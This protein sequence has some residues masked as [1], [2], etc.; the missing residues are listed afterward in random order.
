MT[1][2]DKLKSIFDAKKCEPTVRHIRFPHFK[3]L[4]PFLKLSFTTPITAIVGSNGSNK[5]SVLRA[6]ACCPHQENIGDHW[7]STDVDPID[8]SGGRPRYIFGYE[9]PESKNI[10]EVIKV[11]IKKPNNPDYWEP[12]RP[13]IQDH[14]A[15]MPV[16]KNDKNISG[17]TKTRWSGINKKVELLDF[18]S[19]ISAFDKLFFHGDMTNSLRN[20]TAKEQL[21]SRSKLLKKVINENLQSLKPFKAM[22]EFVS[23]N[24]NLPLDQLME[25]SN[26]LGRE[27][28]EI[29]LVKHKLF[30][31]DSYTAILKTASLQYSE[32]FAGS[33]EFAIVMLVYKIM[34]LPPKSL[35]ILDEPEVSLH[36]G[37]QTKLMEFLTKQ[38]LIKK[39]QIF[40]GT[41]SKHIIEE[42][43]PESIILLQQD[44]STFKIIAEQNIK[45]S[46]AFFHLGLPSINQRR[47]FVED[48]LAAA[49]LKKCLRTL[50]E[51]AM[52]QFEIVVFP[53]GAPSIFGKCMTAMVQT[54]DNN[55]LFYLDGDQKPAEDI[56]PPEN[57]PHDNSTL[58]KEQITKFTKIKNLEFALDGGNDRN[59]DNKRKDL[60]RAFL[61]YALPRTYYLPNQNPEIFLWNAMPRSLIPEGCDMM[62]PKERFSHITK[63]EKGLMPYEE[64]TS[65]DILETQIRKLALIDITHPELVVI[66]ETLR[67]YVE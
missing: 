51:A 21:R 14:M 42:L 39:H 8:D 61:H 23:Y 16:I 41:H 9:D 48:K 67:K 24:K 44:P 38:C 65:G 43:A 33:G 7:F 45:P 59:S 17:R 56:L 5:S 60:E 6:I 62:P 29:R 15:R 47:I 27:Y 53:G 25:I 54:G 49:I 19:E 12:S 22:Q 4:T 57:I 2:N 52:Q 31:S 30:E 20:K 13:L 34:S 32:A 46:E 35:I 11:R 18:R 3:N 50:G 28:T 64:V 63:V 37:A 66:T 58:I 10:V 1:T 26:I 36:P 40:I 55:S